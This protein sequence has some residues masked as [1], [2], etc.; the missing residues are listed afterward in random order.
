MIDIQKARIATI[1]ALVERKPSIGRTA[2]MKL[3]Y[4]L[5]TLR[6]VPLEYRF[7]LY[8]YGPS[9]SDVLSDLASAESFGGLQ[10]DVVLHS[11]S[12]TYEIKP[13]KNSESL[14][15]WASD[16]IAH[17]D[18][19]FNWV[20]KEFGEC[21]SGDLE[22]LGTI[23]YVDRESEGSSEKF[24]LGVLVQTVF[25]IKPQF[26]EVYIRE[27]VKDLANLELLLSLRASSVRSSAA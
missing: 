20:I 25:D 21:E 3:C 4:F 27:R 14:K 13:A 26:D 12:Y 9:D 10:S 23:V 15:A 16:F 11:N 1:V 7:T 8:S 18:P 19:D 17:H 2:L 6:N 22:L 5:Q 24:S